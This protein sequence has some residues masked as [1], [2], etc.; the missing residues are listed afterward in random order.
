MVNLKLKSEPT[1]KNIWGIAGFA[2]CIHRKRNFLL[3]NSQITRE[4][5]LTCAVPKIKNSNS[6]LS[7]RGDPLKFAAVLESCCGNTRFMAMLET[8]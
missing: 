2:F 6:E 4:K 7:I 3:F 8:F 1:L 5:N